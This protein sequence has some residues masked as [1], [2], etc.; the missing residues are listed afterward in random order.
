MRKY[1]FRVKFRVFFI[2]G[3]TFLAGNTSFSEESLYRRV[4][5]LIPEGHYDI[6]SSKSYPSSEAC[7]EAQIQYL[8]IP[9]PDETG[10]KE[11]IQQILLFGGRLNFSL[12]GEMSLEEIP[13][14][15]R[16]QIETL[17]TDKKLTKLT[18]RSKCPDGD[19]DGVTLD[20]LFYE[21]GELVLK[22][23]VNS[24][25]KLRCTYVRSSSE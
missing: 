17:L 3:L 9:M 25:E 14:G 21:S 12:S 15:C 13:D 7:P 8:A 18:E 20:T 24:I 1:F 22:R 23:K 16:Y 10:Q 6:V 11:V 19:G 2:L 5:S 4:K